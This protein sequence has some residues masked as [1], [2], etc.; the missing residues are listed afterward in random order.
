MAP[1]TDA[2]RIINEDTRATA[3]NPVEVCLAERQ[4]VGLAHRSLLLSR[5]GSERGIEDSAAPILNEAGDLLGA[6]LVFHDVS[7]QRRLSNEMSYRASHDW[8]T[9]LVNRAEFDHRLERTLAQCH[10]VPSDN[11]LLYLDLDQ[12]KLVNDACGHTAGDEL[13]QQ[14]SKLFGESLRSRDTLARL[15][16]DE[17]AVILSHCNTVQARRVA[18]KLCDR[19]DVYRFLHEDKRFRVGASIGLAPL[20][21]RWTHIDAVKQAADASC[22]SAK[23]AGRNRVHEWRDTDASMRTRH[24]QMQWVTRIEKALDNNEFV[25]FGQRMEALSAPDAGLHAEVL[26]RLRDDDGSLIPP[27]AFL[28]AA[29]RFH[30]ATRVDRWVVSHA[31]EWLQGLPTLGSIECLCVNLS[32]QSV[33]DSAFHAWAQA[34]LAEAGQDIRSRLCFE[35]TETSAV[36]NMADAALFVD[37]VRAVGVRVALDDFGAGASSFGY[38]HK[39][40]VDYLKIDGQ[41]IRGLVSD[42]LHQAAVRCFIDVSRILGVKTVAEFVEE[43][44]V[45]ERLGAYGVDFAQGYLVHRPAPIDEIL[46]GR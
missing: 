10:E 3:P 26:L 34:L 12:F 27:G 6:V 24:G 44:E 18:Q 17:F 33:G 22:Y 13:L 5:D 14:V 37:A 46:A 20:D 21:A 39:L 8:L 1:L 38:L 25:L 29:E 42:P 32:G 15:G 41:F 16:G 30:L 31:I 23:E 7:E 36:T 9:G 11:V 19:L 35:I 2:F 28:P 43:P 45:M 4:V 40:A